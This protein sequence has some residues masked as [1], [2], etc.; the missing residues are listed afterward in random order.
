MTAGSRNTGQSFMR[1]SLRHR[2]SFLQGRINMKKLMGFA[3]YNDLIL[4]L[5]AVFV[6]D[7]QWEREY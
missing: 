6:L 5:W 1:N 7:L 3:L 2:F 4:Y